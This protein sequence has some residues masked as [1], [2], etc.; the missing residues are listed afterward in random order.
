LAAHGLMIT[1]AIAALMV[2]TVQITRPTYLLVLFAFWR[3]VGWVAGVVFNGIMLCTNH[4]ATRL[5]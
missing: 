5:P 1:T 4:G 3:L 2:T